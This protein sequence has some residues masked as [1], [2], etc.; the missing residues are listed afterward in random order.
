MHPL[1]ANVPKSLLRIN[2][3]LFLAHQLRLLAEQGI[4]DIVIC[5]GHLGEQIEAFAGNGSQFGCRAKSWSGM[6]PELHGQKKG[7]PGLWVARL[8]GN[9]SA[10]RYLGGPFRSRGAVR[11][12]GGEPSG[13]KHVRCCQVVRHEL[14]R[15][16]LVR[17]NQ[18]AVGERHAQHR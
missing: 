8:G 16:A 1:T 3:E 18:G 7:Q 9:L 6:L 10:I 2:G 11:C 5:C 15:R 4:R 13:S 12:L 17:G 14:G